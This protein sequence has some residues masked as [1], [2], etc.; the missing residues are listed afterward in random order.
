LIVAAAQEQ[1]CRFLLTEDLQ[2]GQMFS[3]VRVVDPFKH[4]PKDILA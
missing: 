4:Q 2:D 1:A 3:G